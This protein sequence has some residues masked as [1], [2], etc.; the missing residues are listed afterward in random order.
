M[1]TLSLVFLAALS[2]PVA[3][4]GKKADAPGGANCTAV[5]T[6]MQKEQQ[7]DMFASVRKDKREKWQKKF[8]DAL[9]ET[10]TKD[11]WP[12]EYLTCV[13]QAGSPEAMDKCSMPPEKTDLITKRLDG[14]LQEIVVDLAPGE[15]PK[16]G[17][18]PKA[19][20]A[21]AVNGTGIPE[22]DAY[23]ATVDKIV[24]CEKAPAAAK[25][26]IKQGL[27]AARKSWAA[28]LQ[29]TA[30]AEAKQSAVE[31]CKAGVEQL[32]TSAAELGCPI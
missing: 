8:Q 5:V 20:A 25:D 4:C 1:K 14:L 2:A 24:Q 16:P 29:P 6:K 18:A 26:A 19:E 21:P 10:C 30:P 31:A 27:E 13:D 7:G 22:C 3:G 11:Q 9:I 17:E 23:V 28:A 32:K 12:T 15:G